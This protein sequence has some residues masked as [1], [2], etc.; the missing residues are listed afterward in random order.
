MKNKLKKLKLKMNNDARFYDDD[1][2]G[3]TY[4]LEDYKA[5]YYKKVAEAEYKSICEY[6]KSIDDILKELE[7]V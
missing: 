3:A 2:F 6:I 1:L 4:L 5:G 7:D